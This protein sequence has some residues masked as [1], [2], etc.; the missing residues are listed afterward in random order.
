ME[1]LFKRAANS[2][3]KRNQDAGHATL[4]V[5]VEQAADNE[6]MVEKLSGGYSFAQPPVIGTGNTANVVGVDPEQDGRL[7]PR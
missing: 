3:Q 1:R 4:A 7:D 6:Q 5:S 2:E